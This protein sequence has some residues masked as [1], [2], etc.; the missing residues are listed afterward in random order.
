MLDPVNSKSGIESETH[1]DLFKTNWLTLPYQLDEHILD[2][3][4]YVVLAGLFK[5]EKNVL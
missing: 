3:M 5:F 2:F 1:V 4:Y